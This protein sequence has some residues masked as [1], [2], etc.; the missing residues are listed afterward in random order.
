MVGVQ[1]QYDAIRP[2]QG[3]GFNPA[4]G[5]TVRHDR[6]LKRWIRGFFARRWYIKLW[7]VVFFLGALVTCV[8]GTYSSVK[9]MIDA[10]AS[11]SST[12]FSCVGPV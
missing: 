11:G 1:V 7:N 6:G 8:L 5:E 10:Y 3:E 9:S 2:E 12:A 4:T